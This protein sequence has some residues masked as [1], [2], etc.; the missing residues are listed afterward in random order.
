MAQNQFQILFSPNTF[1]KNICVYVKFRLEK[2][3]VMALLDYIFVRFPFLSCK[4]KNVF[5]KT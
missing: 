1:G 4:T 2:L 5:V 3:D